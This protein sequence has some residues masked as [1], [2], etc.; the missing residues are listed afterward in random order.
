MEKGESVDLDWRSRG[1]RRQGRI[2]ALI[3]A[4]CA[5]AL[6]LP[7]VV[8]DLI[9]QRMELR[10]ADFLTG[11]RGGGE[12]SDRLVLIGIDDASL[13][14]LDVLDEDVVQAHPQLDAMS[15]GYPFPRSVYA[16]MTQKLLDAGARLVVFDMLFTGESDGDAEFK[17]VIDANPDRIVVGCNY[18]IEEIAEANITASRSKFA[19]PSDS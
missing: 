12:A 14:V 5:A 8:D 10:T 16:A 18:V 3:C 13:D 6:I 17:A 9:L 1:R 15:Y 19:L 7:I 4:A 2:N 11:D